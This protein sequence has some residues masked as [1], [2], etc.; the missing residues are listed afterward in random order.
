MTTFDE[1]KYYTAGLSVTE[2]EQLTEPSVDYPVNTNNTEEAYYDAQEDLYYDATATI[3]VDDSLPEADNTTQ[4]HPE[5]GEIPDII[6]LGIKSDISSDSFVDG[7][8]KDYKPDVGKYDGSK[9]LMPLKDPSG[10]AQNNINF[11]RSVSYEVPKNGLLNIE[12]PFY[13][14]GVKGN[15]S[16]SLLNRDPDNNNVRCS[17][18]KMLSSS[19][20]TSQSAETIKQPFRMVSIDDNSS[21]SLLISGD[22]NGTFSYFS[23]FIDKDKLPTTTNITFN[24]KVMPLNHLMFRFYTVELYADA[25][26]TERYYLHDDYHQHVEFDL[27]TR[28]PYSPWMKN[29]WV[30]LRESPYS[31]NIRKISGCGITDA[32]ED[33]NRTSLFT[34]EAPSDAS[35]KAGFFV[36]AESD[37]PRSGPQHLSSVVKHFEISSYHHGCCFW[38]PPYPHKI[39]EASLYIIPESQPDKEIPFT[40]SYKL[41]HPGIPD[42]E[43]V[44]EPPWPNDFNYYENGRLPDPSS[45]NRSKALLYSLAGA[46]VVGLSMAVLTSCKLYRAGNLR[47]HTLTNS[48]SVIDMNEL[49]EV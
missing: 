39:K 28:H 33:T 35:N 32:I 46:G 5:P 11:L 20:G 13:V 25:A 6:R 14:P 49:Q 48:P 37:D 43:D 29:I 15:I 27:T 26:M 30:E 19:T 9:I 45:E 34:T 31:N 44:P 4:T 36:G 38:F 41:S 18:S 12:Q 47:Y 1:A 7:K 40:V 21:C 2:M 24:T 42:V 10:S 17:I 8:N 16:L 3:Q 23:E 22:A